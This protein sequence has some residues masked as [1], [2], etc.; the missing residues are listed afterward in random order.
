MFVCWSWA[1]VCDSP[2]MSHGHLQGDRPAGQVALAGEVDP[3]ERPAAQLLRPAGTRGTRPR[4]GQRRVA[5]PDPVGDRLRVRPASAGPV[6][7]GA[8]GPP[9]SG[10]AAG[11][12]GPSA[13]ARRTS[14]GPA[15]RR[16]RPARDRDGR[17]VRRCRSRRPARYS[18]ADAGSP[19]SRRWRYSSNATAARAPRALEHGREPARYSASRRGRPLAQACSRS[20]RISS[21][22]TARWS[23]WPAAGRNR[24]RSAPGSRP[25]RPRTPRRRWASSAVR[26]G[27]TGVVHRAPRAGQQAGQAV[28]E[29]LEDPLDGPPGPPGPVGDLADLVPLDPQPDDRPVGLRQPGQL[30]VEDHPQEHGG[31]VVPAERPVGRDLRAA[32]GLVDVRLAARWWLDLVAD[33]VQ[34]QDQQQPPD[35]AAGGHVVRLAADPLEERPEDRLDDVVGVEPAGER[36]P[37]P[38]RAARARSRRAYRRYRAVAAASSPSRYR[39][40]RLPSEMD[41]SRVSAAGG[42]RG[43]SLT[44][45]LRKGKGVRD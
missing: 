23:G 26:D 10:P 34:G 15:R 12:T 3:A 27:G 32:G 33:L 19:A 29:V 18:R 24:P 21:A 28:A 9:R 11:R 42:R 37:G 35:L 7:R 30:L 43:D 16:W 22:R 6:G 14:A 1:S 45:R 36:R 8:I 25:G 39:R 41:G 38:L 5:D 20:T 31:G 2:T 4:L 40:T 44:G 13:E 17:P